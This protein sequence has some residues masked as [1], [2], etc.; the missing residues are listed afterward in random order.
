MQISLYANA[1]CPIWIIERQTD[2]PGDLRPI[3]FGDNKDVTKNRFVL[4]ARG[5]SL[6]LAQE[7]CGTF[8]SFG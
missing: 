7:G 2:G 6:F 1:T 8:T 4:F 5:I 3:E